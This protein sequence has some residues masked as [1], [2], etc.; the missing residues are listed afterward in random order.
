M[1]KIL[2]FVAAFALALVSMPFVF[3][4]IAE[5]RIKSA[6]AEANLPQGMILE[7]KSYD[8]G[9]RQSHAVATL[10]IIEE[11]RPGQ[12]QAGK[13]EK[14][15][16]NLEADV[17][18]GP[19]LESGSGLANIH[20]YIKPE[21]L[22]LADQAM[23]ENIRK[24]FADKYIVSINTHL[25][26]TGTLHSKLESSAANYQ[27]EDGTINWGGAKGEITLAG[28]NSQID[29]MIDISPLLMQANN[30]ATL[31]FSRISLVS[32]AK[33]SRGMPWVGE[34]SMNIPSFYMKDEKGDEVRF[35][36]LVLHANTNLEKKLA[37]MHF[38]AKADSLEIYKQPFTNIQLDI[39]IGKLE[40]AS[41]SK[42]SDLSQTNM[43]LM[44]EEQ[45]NEFT[46][47]VIDMLS[48]GTSF[49]FKHDM[50]ITEGPVNSHITLQFPE[51]T[52][53]L[54]KES[55]E[56][57]SQHLL[58]NIIASLSLQTPKN[59]LEQTL[60]SLSAGEIPADAHA[61]TDPVTNQKITPQEALHREIKNQLKTFTQS[62]ILVADETH[63]ALNLSYDAG[64]ITLNGN[65]LTQDD[66]VKLMKVISGK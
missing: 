63:Y 4:L 56:V 14:V 22:A 36:N 60:Y 58:K 38:S 62:G 26:F 66:V 57:L 42:F 28:D 24:V 61:I 43:N 46:R 54:E 11:P 50:N 30:Q 6:L 64:A 44:T 17:T 15:S 37:D 39:N 10:S 12:P 9:Y 40:A 16:F 8:R 5:H 45:R 33:R 19:W 49:E 32:N 47:I 21:D 35:A 51:I 27:A 48:P 3:G 31:D 59:W 41:F 65:K 7:I 1:R 25:G 2:L 55:N 18:H 34:Q 52:S 29:V 23:V 13:A 20:I 53:T